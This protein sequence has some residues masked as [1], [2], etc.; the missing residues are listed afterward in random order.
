MGIDQNERARRREVDKPKRSTRHPYGAF[1]HRITDSPAYA[2]LSF[3][4]RS[5]LVLIVRQLTKDNNG[6]LQASF[7]WCKKYGIGSEHTLRGAVADLIEHGMIYRTRSH[8]A[9]GAWARYAVTWL[10]VKNREG[11]FLDRFKPCAWRDCQPDQEKSTRQKVP[12][13][14]GRKCSFTP[15]H[16]AESAG[17]PTAKNAPYVLIP[18]RERERGW[19]PPFIAKLKSRDLAGHQCFQIPRRKVLQ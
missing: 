4:A 8:G 17:K 16:P 1:E 13:E 6:H 11:L 18:S 7:A 10:P 5:L 15:E 19:I 14:S 2:D 12:D 9:N 3:S